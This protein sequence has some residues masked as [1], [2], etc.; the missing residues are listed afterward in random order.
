MRNVQSAHSESPAK[1]ASGSRA[2]RLPRRG[3]VPMTVHAVAGPTESCA[4]GNQAT[5]R[6]RSLSGLT[7]PVTV[8]RVR[9]RDAIGKGGIWARFSKNDSSL[10]VWQ[11]ARRPL[12]DLILLLVACRPRAR[13]ILRPCA[14]GVAVARPRAR[15]GRRLGGASCKVQV[16][17]GS[18][19]MD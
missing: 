19:S 7:L 13:V 12:S 16:W 5:G 1:P 15:I 3:H 2:Q 10:R 6:W 11:R 17:A 14:V 4:P 18:R 8:S 9:A